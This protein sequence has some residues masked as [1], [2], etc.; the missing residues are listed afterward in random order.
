MVHDMSRPAEAGAVI[1]T[2]SPVI[3]KINQDKAKDKCPW[4]R[5]AFEKRQS[6][7]IMDDRVNRKHKRGWDEGQ[8]LLED[9]GPKVR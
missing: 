9:S 4:I 5:P 7:V 1:H 8:R 2:M 3:K 6:P